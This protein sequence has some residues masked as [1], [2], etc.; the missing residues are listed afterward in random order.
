MENIKNTH[1]CSM[2]RQMNNQVN[3]LKM[4]EDNPNHNSG[5]PWVTSEPCRPCL[6]P[7]FLPRRVALEV[8]DPSLA[9]G[10][11]VSISTSSSTS[12]SD[13]SAGG[14]AGPGGRIPSRGGR[15]LRLG[16]VLEMVSGVSGSIICKDASP[17]RF[18]SG[19]GP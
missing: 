11:S 14:P 2:A 4:I 3:S 6:V 13:D 10:S 5:E 18:G 1:T 7:L 15:E 12:P 16:G 17:S 19:G 9:G 8:L